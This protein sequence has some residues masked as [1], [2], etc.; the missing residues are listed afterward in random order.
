[1]LTFL[2]FLNELAGDLD[3]AVFAYEQALRHNQR[4]ARIMNTISRIL[5]RTEK[6]PET[7]RL[8]QNILK[9]E[10]ANGEIWCNLGTYK[11][12]QRDLSAADR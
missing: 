5:C 12:L 3:D 7:I 9:L 1:M 8:L 4:S 6:Y 10:P 2:G 11:C